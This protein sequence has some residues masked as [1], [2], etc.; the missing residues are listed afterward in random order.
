MTLYIPLPAC[1]RFKKI[2]DKSEI[3]QRWLTPDHRVISVWY[4]ED[5]ADLKKLRGMLNDN[6]IRFTIKEQ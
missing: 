6:R 1:F 2:Y 4:I 3:L 5:C